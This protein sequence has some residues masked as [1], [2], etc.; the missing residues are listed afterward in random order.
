MDKSN[1]LK[2]RL[3]YVMCQQQNSDMEKLFDAL[4]DEFYKEM[5]SSIELVALL[6]MIEEFYADK[7]SFD[8]LIDYIQSGSEND[9]TKQSENEM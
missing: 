9:I 5:N 1:S 6:G 2:N 4:I 8:S 7:I 3:D